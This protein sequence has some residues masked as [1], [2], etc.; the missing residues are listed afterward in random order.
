MLDYLFVRIP[1]TGSSSICQALN[2]KEFPPHKTA[3]EWSKELTNFDSLF[4]FSI[5]RDPYDR[6]CSMCRFFDCK[7]E[8]YGEKVYFKTQKEFLYINSILAVDYVGRFEDLDNSF[9]EITKRIG[10]DLVL[11][12]YIKPNLGHRP[13]KEEVKDIVNKYFREDFELFDYP[14]EL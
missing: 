12:P 2:L 10:L 4:K 9:K 14:M 13:K 11:P 5:V 7:L 8:E 1:K 3:S 6:F